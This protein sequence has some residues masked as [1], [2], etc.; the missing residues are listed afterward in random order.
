MCLCSFLPD[1]ILKDAVASTENFVTEAQQEVAKVVRV[2]EKDRNGMLAPPSSMY[3]IS[4]DEKYELRSAAKK[5]RI[6]G[7]CSWQV[8]RR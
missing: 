3:I 6:A 1:F 4:N 8:M 2:N 7:S 5:A